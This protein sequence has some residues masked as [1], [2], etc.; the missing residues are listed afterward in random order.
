MLT[1]LRAQ[2]LQGKASINYQLCGGERERYFAPRKKT[3][4]LSSREWGRWF[5]FPIT[6]EFRECCPRMIRRCKF[7]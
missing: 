4:P 2:E 1:E 3:A 6:A 5:R 7:P